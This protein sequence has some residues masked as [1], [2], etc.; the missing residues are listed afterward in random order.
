[1]SIFLVIQVYATVM[2][3]EKTSIL[4][5]SISTGEVGKPVLVLLLFVFLSIG[6][7]IGE[8][9][10]VGFFIADYSAAVR[11]QIFKKV[12]KMSL[13]NINKFSIPSLITR[14]TN[15][16][17]QIEYTLNMFLTMAI[18]APATAIGGV[19]KMGTTLNLKTQ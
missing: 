19:I 18:S 3:P 1:M 9:I 17:K 12:N 14:T 4:L 2:T 6:G 16:T 5:K 7:M 8:G 15:D 10:S 13:E 11:T